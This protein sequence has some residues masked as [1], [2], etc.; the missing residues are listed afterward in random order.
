MKLITGIMRR[1]HTN[2][3]PNNVSMSF[4]GPVCHV[5]YYEENPALK[6]SFDEIF[7]RFGVYYTF[8]NYWN[9]TC[10]EKGETMYLTLML[11][12]EDYANP[13][14][15]VCKTL[16]DG[17]EIFKEWNNECCGEYSVEGNR[18]DW[19]DNIGWESFAVCEVYELNDKPYVLMWWHA[20]NGVDFSVRQF[21][22]FEE[23]NAAMRAEVDNIYDEADVEACANEPITPDD[24]SGIVDDGYEWNCWKIVERSEL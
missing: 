22:T 3:N 17:F 8:G 10:Y 12:D 6:K 19:V 11:G 2:D 14:Y 16:A 13:Y 18:C 20:Y 23:A 9:F 15:K 1:G 4:E 7:E 21:D 5:I 24:W